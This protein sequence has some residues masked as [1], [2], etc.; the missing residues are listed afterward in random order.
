MR[1]ASWVAWLR[2]LQKRKNEDMLRGLVVASFASAS[3]LVFRGCGGR[4][5]WEIVND[6]EREL[7]GGG[8]ARV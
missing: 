2:P 1:Y 4:E 3:A 7:K 5:S 6:E 8:I